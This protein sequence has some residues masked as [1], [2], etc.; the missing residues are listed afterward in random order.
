MGVITDGKNEQSQQATK[1]CDKKTDN[2]HLFCNQTKK[3][4]SQNNIV[5]TAFRLESFTNYSGKIYER[6]W[7]AKLIKQEV[8]NYNQHKSKLFSCRKCI[9]QRVYCKNAFKSLGFG[10][11]IYPN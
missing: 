3:W 1:N 10:Y 8:Q 6:T 4:K 9:K 5:I 7:L 2:I 11:Y